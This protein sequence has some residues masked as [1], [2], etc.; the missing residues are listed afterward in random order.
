MKPLFT[1]RL[2]AR[3]KPQNIHWK[4]TTARTVKLWKTMASADLRRDMPP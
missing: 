3:L 2:K 4:V 1:S